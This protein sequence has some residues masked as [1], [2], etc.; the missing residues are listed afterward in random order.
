MNKMLGGVLALA[1]TLGSANAGVWN[2]CKTVVGAPVA[3]G[4]KR[5]TALVLTAGAAHLVKKAADKALADMDAT[6]LRG[7]M[8]TLP[9]VVTEK[10]AFTKKFA[11]IEMSEKALKR[12][13]LWAG[14]TRFL[15][16]VALVTIAG[17]RTAT[18]KFGKESGAEWAGSWTA[19][20][21]ANTAAKEAA[22][23]RAEVI[24][25][26][27]LDENKVVAGDDAATPA[28][29]ARFDAT[30]EHTDAVK[31]LNARSTVAEINAAVGELP[32]DNTD[33]LNAVF[34][35]KF[36]ALKDAD[37]PT[38]GATFKAAAKSATAAL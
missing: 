2:T 1:L 7:V 36:S 34:G 9:S 10:F 22:D 14:H 8:T 38:W 4:N 3:K 24:A 18:W 28:V 25:T 12:V 26:L 32:R 27:K 35:A 37:A 29:P 33:S 15:A 6:T 17:A 20:R 16:I 31:A 19:N 5:I 21:T 23:A 13:S 11:G 30:G